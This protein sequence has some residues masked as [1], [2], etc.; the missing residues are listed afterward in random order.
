MKV[1]FWTKNHRTQFD[2]G[3]HFYYFSVTKNNR[4]LVIFSEGV[5]GTISDNSDTAYQNE[6]ITS[7]M[8]DT[9]G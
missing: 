1:E 3:M 5:K 4:N 6:T 8:P 7:R 2:R 9:L